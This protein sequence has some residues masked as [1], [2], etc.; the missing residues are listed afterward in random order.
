M[1]NLDYIFRALTVEGRLKSQLGFIFNLP[2]FA[3]SVVEKSLKEGE[4]SLSSDEIIILSSEFEGSK[5]ETLIDL[6]KFFS[7][8]RGY[9]VF[10]YDDDNKS[11]VRLM[12]VILGFESPLSYC[13]FFNKEE[14]AKKMVVARF[15]V[16]LIDLRILIELGYYDLAY[17]KQLLGKLLANNNFQIDFWVEYDTYMVDKKMKPYVEY[18]ET[19][20]KGE[21]SY[22]RN[23]EG[24]CVALMVYRG[25]T[26]DGSP[27]I[28]CFYKKDE[29]LKTIIIHHICD[30]HTKPLELE[31]LEPL[32]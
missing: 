22:V 16:A 17:K 25:I 15:N 5:E 8:T 10:K 12:S 30:G 6:I 21:I 19:K 1:T 27:N 29:N 2:T 23:V 14:V 7:K 28:W 4:L 11:Y 20:G 26:K 24:K 18:L 32:Y 3:S 9:N 13:S 31:D